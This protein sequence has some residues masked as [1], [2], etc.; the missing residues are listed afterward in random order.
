MPRRHD[1]LASWLA[2]RVIT[3]RQADAGER[4]RLLFDVAGL[5]GHAIID[6]IGPKAAWPERV[7]GAADSRM[8]A[9][10]ELKA[11][12]GTLGIVDFALV[13]R[14]IG[15]GRELGEDGTSD[16]DR[17]YL[18]HRIRDALGVMAARFAL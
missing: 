2:H 17:R 9:R 8:V 10:D 4:F 13:C 16:A 1:V 18:A 5:E 3:P 14:V 12:R 11:L 7:R 15:T 6:P